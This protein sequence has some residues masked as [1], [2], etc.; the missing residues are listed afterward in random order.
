MM[1]DAVKRELKSRKAAIER[2]LECIDH[3]LSLYMAKPKIPGCARFA[4]ISGISV[5]ATNVILNAVAIDG[6]ASSNITFR[7][8]VDFIEGKTDAELLREPNFGRK[9]L[10]EVRAFKDIIE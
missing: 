10:A 7:E 2:E 1:T 9:L 8:A 6:K 5:R 4:E 3:L